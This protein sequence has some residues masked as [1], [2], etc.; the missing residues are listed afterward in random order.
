MRLARSADAGK[1]AS[2]AA[3]SAA[4]AVDVEI[5]R[6]TTRVSDTQ[7]RLTRAAFNRLLDTKDELMLISYLMYL[8]KDHAELAYAGV[9]RRGHTSKIGA[10]QPGLAR[11]PLIVM[12]D[13]AEPVGVAAHAIHLAKPFDVEALGA[14]VLEAM[15]GRGEQ[16]GTRPP[17]HPEV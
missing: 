7:Y 6:G 3:A 10:E 17:Q 15:S 5:A 8:Q 16:P 2:A 11:I 14:A 4:A 12:T 13:G 1:P 9:T